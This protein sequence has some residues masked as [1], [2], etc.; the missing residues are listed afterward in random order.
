MSKTPLLIPNRARCHADIT[1]KKRALEVLSELI[2][3]GH[4]DLTPRDVL[5]CLVSREKLGSTGLGHGVAIPHGRMIHV[6]SAVGAALTL[7]NGVD[8]DAPDGQ[9]VDL[10][11]GLI[12]PEESADEHLHIL[13]N[14]AEAFSDPESVRAVREAT[15]PEELSSLLGGF[16]AKA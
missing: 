13:A 6:H 8:F 12:V 9:P 11:V 7:R 14:L 4:D 16:L 10:I 5:N 3:G 1:S 15:T 2:S